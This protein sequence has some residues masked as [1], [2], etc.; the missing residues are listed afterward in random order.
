MAAKLKFPDPLKHTLDKTI[1]LCPKE[2]V[3]KLYKQE[4]GQE[5]K[6]LTLKIAKWFDAEARK[7]GWA[8][9]SLSATT[10]KNIYA[11]CSLINKKSID[12][13]LQAIC[14]TADE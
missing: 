5:A 11:G 3:L 10:K 4:T 6:S 2:E 1:V 8:G 7:R 9:C 12:I 14:I 13:T